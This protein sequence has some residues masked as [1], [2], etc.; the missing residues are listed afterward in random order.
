M[1]YLIYWVLI[2]FGMG[3]FTS[4]YSIFL[5]RNLHIDRATSSL[6]VSLSYLA[7]VLFLLFT[8]GWSDGLGRL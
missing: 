4:Y 8:P 1:I 2:S 7:I 3:L 6:L 5:N